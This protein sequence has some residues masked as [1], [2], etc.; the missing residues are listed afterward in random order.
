MKTAD[1]QENWISDD[2]LSTS[3]SIHYPPQLVM[4]PFTRAKW[5]EHVD[6]SSLGWGEGTD[7]LRRFWKGQ[8][9]WWR[10]PWFLCVQC[11]VDVAESLSCILKAFLG[12]RCGTIA[13]IVFANEVFDS[14]L[15]EQCKHGHWIP[16]SCMLCFEWTS[17]VFLKKYMLGLI[18]VEVAQTAMW[19]LI[20]VVRAGDLKAWGS[21]PAA[22]C[23]MD[24]LQYI[25]S[26]LII[27]GKRQYLLMTLS[28]KLYA[29]KHWHWMPQSCF[30]S[31]KVMWSGG[32]GIGW[33]VLLKWQMSLSF[34]PYKE[35]SISFL[36]WI[37]LLINNKGL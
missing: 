8:W 15:A 9:C 5:Q 22:V 17:F 3:T 32:W 30:D 18:H 27:F 33:H 10:Q 2:G 21:K 20:V 31:G 29:V 35:V 6:V 25:C 14:H 23:M 12:W 11:S 16:V 26:T 4:I 19:A 1:E 7:A 13:W 37:K 34:V 28:V 24:P 36:L